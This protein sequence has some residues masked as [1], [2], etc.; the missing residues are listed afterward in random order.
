MEDFEKAVE[1]FA[2]DLVDNFDLQDPTYEIWIIGYDADQNI[3]D[4]EKLVDTDTNMDKAIKKLKLFM[5]T[6]MKLLKD[7]LKKSRLS[8]LK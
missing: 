5:M 1:E 2:E 8:V 4:F 7:F 3:T 6:L